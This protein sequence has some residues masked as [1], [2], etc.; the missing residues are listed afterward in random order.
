[1]K[2]HLNQEA[3]PH[4]VF[5]LHLISGQDRPKDPQIWIPYLYI[6]IWIPVYAQYRDPEIAKIIYNNCCMK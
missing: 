6:R 2:S 3:A 5:V 4:F 1:M